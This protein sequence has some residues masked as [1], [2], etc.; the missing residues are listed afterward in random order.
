VF[1]PL[2]I[3]LSN[4]DLAMA[5]EPALWILVATDSLGVLHDVSATCEAMAARGRTPDHLVLS[6]AREPD[7]STGSNGAELMT[8]GIAT[9]SALLARNDD[10]GIAA[11]VD[12][13]L[14]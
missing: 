13:L 10:R 3:R 14:A 1:S 4:F 11:L 12:R 6:Q 9:P 8:L 7:A 2:G 5:L